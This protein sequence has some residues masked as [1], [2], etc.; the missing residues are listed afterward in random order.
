MSEG[1]VRCASEGLLRDSYGQNIVL[2]SSRNIERMEE[3]SMVGEKQ[4]V[5]WQDEGKRGEERR[6]IH[7][8]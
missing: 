3:T 8:S 2:S 1:A 7:E 6:G 4:A 5:G